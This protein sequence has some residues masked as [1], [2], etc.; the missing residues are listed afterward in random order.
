EMEL[1]SAR[2]RGVAHDRLASL[3][4]MAAGVAHEINNPM[5]FVSSNVALLREDL[6]AGPLADAV[7][8]EYAEDILPATEEG[9]RR[10]IDITVDLRRFARGDSAQ[11]VSFD[12]NQEVRTAIRM[13]E[14]TLGQRRVSSS[15][16]A[17]PP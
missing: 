1:Q 15:L 9:I 6:A 17:L 16:A 10:I 13:C 14:P 3:G 2:E 5:T 4:R 12:L 7:R 8:R 11:A